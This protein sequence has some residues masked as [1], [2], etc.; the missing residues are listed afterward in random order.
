MV[1]RLPVPCFFMLLS[2]DKARGEGSWLLILA[3]GGSFTLTSGLCLTCSLQAAVPWG[4]SP[5]PFAGFPQEPPVLASLCNAFS[6]SVEVISQS[7]G[8]FQ[9]H[10]A[11][12]A[13]HSK[14]QL[15]PRSHNPPFPEND[16]TLQGAR[17]RKE[18]PPPERCS[19]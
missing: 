7:Q 10:C 1:H 16:T 14:M 11:H 5:C 8:K 4:A 2:W 15:P 12:S 3:E 17:V 9:P 6:F 13:P 19:S 18:T